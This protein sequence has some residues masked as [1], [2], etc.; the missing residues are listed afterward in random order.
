MSR[1]EGRTAI[2]MRVRMRAHT[3]PDGSPPYPVF[4]I[5]EP[6]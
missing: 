4:D 3:P 6:A 2:G 5:E 1:V